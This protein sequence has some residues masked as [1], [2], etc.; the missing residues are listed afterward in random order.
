MLD[1]FTDAEF[2]C[3]Y[4]YDGER[5]QVHV[6][7]D[8]SVKVRSKRRRRPTLCPRTPCACRARPRRLCS[9]HLPAVMRPRMRP[10]NGRRSTAATART[11]RASTPT[12]WPWCPSSSRRASPGEEGTLA[13]RKRTSAGRRRCSLAP[14]APHLPLTPAPP[15]PL[16]RMSAAW[17]WTPRRWRLTRRPARSCPSRLAGGPL[18]TQ[19]LLP[20]SAGRRPGGGLTR[21]CRVCLDPAP[22]ASPPSCSCA[23]CAGAVDAGAQ[24]R[25]GGEHQGVWMNERRCLFEGRGEGRKGRSR[26]AA[27][28]P[29]QCPRLPSHSRRLASPLPTPHNYRSPCASSSSTASRSTAA[30]CCAS[31]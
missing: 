9:T 26:A 19:W 25:D 11:T 20:C 30:R 21:S 2:T 16:M 29:Q 8:G 23:S 14:P 7:A 10:P 31:R 22:P 17:C 24:G 5:A 13:G 12:S 1:K 18:Q 28:R 15:S 27:L 6:L 3:E 4:K